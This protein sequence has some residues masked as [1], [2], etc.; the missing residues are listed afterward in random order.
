MNKKQNNIHPNIRDLFS[1]GNAKN[2]A[3]DN[4]MEF[5]MEKLGESKKLDYWVITGI[6]GNGYTPVYNKSDSTT[7]CDYC[8]SGYLA[9][10]DYVNYIF[11]SI[12][13][14][15][16]Y[17]TSE[18]LNAD[19]SRYIQKLKDYIDRGVPVIAI[20][21][22]NASSSN[23]DALTHYLYVR[24]EDYKKTLLFSKKANDELYH[25]LSAMESISQDWIFAE[26]KIHDIALI[27]IC[28]NVVMKLPYW[29]T[30]PERNG[31]FFGPSA[32]RAWADDIEVGRYKGEIDVFHNYGVYMCN[33]A[34][35]AWANNIKD[36][37]YASIINRLA[38]MD[39]QYADMS[40][41]IA[42]QYFILGEENGMHGVN[43]GIWK[44]LE[45]FGAGLNHYSR[46]AFLSK[47][48]C[49]KITGKFREAAHCMDNVVQIL[50]K[51]LI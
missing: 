17:V 51:N 38:Q 1:Y 4:C 10:S 21:Y 48:N 41:Q 3:F 19:K 28:R 26:E 24:Q 42:E 40:I 8:V 9:G 20:S 6:T 37:P 11:D 46:D 14:G 12:G 13:Y 45:D 44:D 35:I 18:E 30:F 50:Q 34:T 27:D 5:L 16:T 31:V 33:L 29:L 7:A 36:A 43:S 23:I 39:S 2:F 15:H 32:Y 25:K 47:E 49:V 22:S